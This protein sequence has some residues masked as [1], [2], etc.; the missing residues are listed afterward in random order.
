MKVLISSC[1]HWWNAEAA[2]A[3]V[4]ARS[5]LENGHQVLVWTPPGTANEANLQRLGLPLTGTIPAA[6][7]NPLGW[8][9]TLAGLAA[10]QEKEGFEIVDVFRSSELPLHLLNSRGGRGP[11]VVRTRGSAQPVGGGW[12]NRRMYGRWC[13]GLIAS[14]ESVRRQMVSALR[15]D[16]D[17]SPEPS[18]QQIRTIYYPIDLPEAAMPAAISKGRA[19]YLKSLGFPEDSFVIG[20]VGRLFREK[21]HARLLEAMQALV[22]RA[23][24][25][26]LIIFSKDAP[27]EDPERPALEAQVARAGMQAHVRFT[28]YL[29]NMRQIMGWMHVGA[30]PSLSSEVNCRVA[31][32]FFSVG[33]PVVAFPTGALP[34]V[35]E[36]GVSGLVTASHDA[37]QLAEAL[38]SLARDKALRLKLGQGAREQAE[39]RFS[40]GRFLHETLEVFHMALDG[41]LEGALPGAPGARP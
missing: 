26:V 27:G 33:V 21:G 22:R 2:Y 3:A 19:E 24:R 12:L 20:I 14:S 17:L 30:V 41:A 7:I 6:G 8:R 25:A 4:L 38:E 34:E 39:T 16:S 1:T 35:V 32:E 40:R 36:H 31:V 15:L 5:L 18:Q 28:G 9:A 10:L 29:E 11:L 13:S 23:P 37:A